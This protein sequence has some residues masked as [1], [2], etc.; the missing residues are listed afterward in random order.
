MMRNPRWA[1]YWPTHVVLRIATLGNVG[2][3]KAPGTW[4]SAAGVLLYVVLFYQLTGFFGILLML[5]ACYFAI[6]I[7]G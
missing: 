3:L 1:R 2:S 7:C 5:G 6:G 4:G